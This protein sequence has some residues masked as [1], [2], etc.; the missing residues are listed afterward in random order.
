MDGELKRIGSAGALALIPLLIS[1]QIVAPIFFQNGGGSV[2]PYCSGAGSIYPSSPKPSGLQFQY[3]A[4]S[5]SNCDGV[6]HQTSWSDSSGNS[7]TATA[8]SGTYV[9]CSTNQINGKPAISTGGAADFSIGGSAISSN[10]EHTLFAII[11]PGGGTNQNLVGG[12]SGEFG[13]GFGISGTA[14]GLQTVYVPGAP[15]FIIK[16]TAT[17]STSTWHSIVA[18]ESGP[19]SG[20]GFAGLFHLD[21]AADTLGT[22]GTAPRNATPPQ[23]LFH[24]VPNSPCC[25]INA[26]IAEILYYNTQLSASD[27][28]YDECYLYGEY[29]R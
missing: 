25:D 29:L 23:R 19:L 6:T 22:L 17:V 2:I 14:S 15:S 9:I 3:K 7:R 26:S 12:N 16:G 11:N 20:V 28:I 21:E 27:I 24:N 13:Y 4:S 10:D 1:A 5:L 18:Q 8:N